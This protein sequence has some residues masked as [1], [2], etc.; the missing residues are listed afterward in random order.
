MMKCLRCVLFNFQ[1]HFF[2]FHMILII[3]S[4]VYFLQTSSTPTASV[5]EASVGDSTKSS[6]PLHNEI[7][8][9]KSSAEQQN[10]NERTISSVN[11]TVSSAP[12]DQ[13]AATI[14]DSEASKIATVSVEAKTT[15]VNNVDSSASSNSSSSNQ[16]IIHTASSSIDGSVGNDSGIHIDESKSQFFS[17]FSVKLTFYS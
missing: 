5:E 4:F 7:P 2:P 15:P 1:N 11:K 14:A 6:S 10:I 17:I 16:N 8:E 13:S 12:S 3:K 9:N